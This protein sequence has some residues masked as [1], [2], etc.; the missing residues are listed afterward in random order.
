MLEY[1][2]IQR[3]IIAGII[4]AILASFS[5]F[6]IVLKRYSLI[7]ETLSHASLVGVAVGIVSSFSP[8]YMAVLFA[9]AFSFI[10]EYLKLKYDLYS[11]SILSII[12]SGALAFAVIIV[13]VGGG[14]N[15]SL[16]NYLFGSIL[17]VDIDDLIL[18]GIV[19][20]ISFILL[21][22]NANRFYFIAYDEEVAK[23]S[24]LNVVFLNFLLVGIVSI[25][26]SIS[27]SVVG[28]L[29]I[30]ALL[31]IPVNSALLFRLGFLKT[32]LLSLFFSTISVISG[33]VLSYYISIPSGASIVLSV[34]F[35]FIVSLILNRK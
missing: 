33:I 6:F 2:F 35:I 12:L 23:V 26:I 22:F 13:S 9:L 19:G 7:G 25:V 30:G 31:V 28:S 11:D 20:I 18:M 10:I 15:N 27:I 4:I 8:L 34:I 1:D 24:G 17:A 5:G 14:F 21:L 32:I 3:A 29:L 16:Y